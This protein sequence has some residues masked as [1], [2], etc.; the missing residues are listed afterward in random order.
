M[1]SSFV[2]LLDILLTTQAIVIMSSLMYFILLFSPLSLH[3]IFSL[4]SCFRIP[5]VCCCSSD[6][7]TVSMP[8]VRAGTTQESR[9]FFLPLSGNLYIYQYALS[10][11]QC[12]RS[13][14]YSASNIFLYVIYFLQ[15]SSYVAV[16]L[17]LYSMSTPSLHF[18]HLI[19]LPPTILFGFVLLDVLAY[20]RRSRQSEK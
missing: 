7:A 2:W 5:V 6:K 19:V 14:L 8:Y 11:S 16:T 17:S 9:T 1:S 15:S 3:R 4:S 13:C 10:F 18:P 20:A 12:I